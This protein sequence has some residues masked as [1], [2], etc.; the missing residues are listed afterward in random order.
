MAEAADL[1]WRV[2][3][4]ATCSICLDDF[5]NSK[6]LPCVHSFCL[7]C[8]QSHYNDKKHGDVV[9]CPMCRKEFQIPDTGLDALP[10]NF[11]LQ[12]LIDARDA[13]SL[14]TEEV[15][16]EVCV[17]A[18]EEDEDKDEILSATMYCIDCNQ[19][20]CRRC[21]RSCRVKSRGEP[22]H[23]RPLGAEMT[24]ELIQQRSSY[25]DQ[26]KD[27]KLKL[28]CHDCEI[29]VCLMC[30]AEDH[31]GHKCINV[32]KAAGEFLEQFE[33]YIRSVS[34]RIDDFR[35]AVAQVDAENTKFVNV[36]SENR[37]HIQQKGEAV[38]H[39]TQTHVNRLLQELQMAESNG[40]EEASNRSEEL[41]L[42]LTCLE[43]F[44]IYLEEVKSKG[45][46]CDITQVAKAMRC[47]ASELLETYIIPNDYHAPCVSFNPMNIDELTNEEQN[48]IG[49]ISL[50]TRHSGIGLII[51]YFAF[52]IYYTCIVLLLSAKLFNVGTVFRPPKK[53][54]VYRCRKLAEN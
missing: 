10:H 31:N 49:R 33:T 51:F 3:E 47:R 14:K 18:E 37:T 36:V 16:C 22:H 25:C 4:I 26:H 27:E 13:S 19:K 20:L 29:N 52:G 35:V 9:A 6:M 7:E 42:A 21:S 53:S 48:L 44:K 1:K 41:K 38:N 12:N 34:S 39:I 2:T 17:A 5:K 32:G 15:L 11:F 45:S 43:S 46:P 8:L 50:Q 40:M 24:A 28:Y 54:I 23:V 30:F